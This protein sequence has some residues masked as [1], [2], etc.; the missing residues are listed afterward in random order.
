VAVVFPP[1]AQV[2]IEVLQLQAN[3][4]HQ[5]AI[6][7]GIC[8]INEHLPC[9]AIVVMDADG[10]DRPEDA[11]RLIQLA[12]S[13][14]AIALLAERRRR[15]A[16]VTFGLGYAIFRIVH[17]LLTGIPV[18]VGNFSLLPRSMLPT[19]TR[20]PELW[21]H[22]AGAV[23]KSRVRRDQVPMDRGRRLKGR[24]KMNITSLVTHGI[25][26]IA[27][28]SETVTTRILL[29]NFFFVVLLGIVLA[30]VVGLRILTDLAIPGW[31]TY[32]VGII[33][34]LVVQSLSISFGLVF[35]QISNR[36]RME[37]IPIRDYA[38]FVAQLRN[39]TESP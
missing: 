24:S 8:Y 22:Y 7:V 32:T 6:C 33:L 12:I 20:M 14:P 5:R 28:F 13:R 37:F 29:A 25:A 35:S 10:E 15:F 1:P 36:T 34:I 38:P 2:Q 11:V 3:L 18:R 9:D 23:I 21:N 27:T 4:G 31:A 17:L 30:I 39:L 19:L 16:G 26:G